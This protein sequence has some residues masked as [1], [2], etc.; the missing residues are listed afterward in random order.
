MVKRY[1]LT[2]EWASKSRSRVS[3]DQCRYY[4]PSRNGCPISTTL[5]SCVRSYASGAVR[6]R[7]RGY[8]YG[9]SEWPSGPS[10]HMAPRSL[11]VATRKRRLTT[12]VVGEPSE[13][14]TMLLSIYPAHR[15]RRPMFWPTRHTGR[16]RVRL[17]RTPGVM[18]SQIIPPQYEDT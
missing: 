17:F 18:Y 3:K 16:M 2:I 8:E 6:Y 10:L 7:Q 5:S 1:P 14:A 9:L 12:G 11:S 13:N 15:P 4:Y